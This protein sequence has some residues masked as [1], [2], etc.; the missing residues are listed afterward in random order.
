MAK[1]AASAELHPVAA[2]VPPEI[3]QGVQRWGEWH[4]PTPPTLSQ[5]VAVALS[6]GADS[7]ALLLAAQAMWPGRV[8]AIHINHGL[9]SASQEFAA[10]CHALCQGL[11]VHLSVAAVDVHCPQGASLEAQAR[12]HRYAALADEAQR[13]NAVA[14]LL[15]HHA[16]DQA[17]TVL[18]AL[19]RGAGLPGLSA[20]GEHSLKHG[21]LFG[22]PLLAVRGQ[23]IRQWLAASGI[24][25]VEDPTNL[26]LAFTRN[27]I[28]HRLL[29]T[30][31]AE[32]PAIVTTLSRTARHAAEATG[33]LFELAQDDLRHVGDPP[34]LKKLQSLPRAR[35]ANVLRHW[36]L[37]AAG[38]A[39][40]TAQLD[41]LLSQVTRCVTRGHAISI[42]VTSGRVERVGGRL[43]YA[44]GL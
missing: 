44:A 21:V 4:L 19:T 11:Q 2:T 42:K 43:H 38:A 41:E 33:L 1:P 27:L 26:D 34:E 35:Q 32:F 28:R 36:L 5:P 7:V 40:S 3:R 39:P 29:P 20:M 10:A 15:G 6:G 14:V 16:D 37:S 30:L 23:V 8:A 31:E 9:Q 22:R 25:F 13:L 12:A 24:G 18:L 17:E